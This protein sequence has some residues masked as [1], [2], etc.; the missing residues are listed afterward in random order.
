MRVVYALLL[1]ASAARTQI[2][3]GLDLRVDQ[4]LLLLG[5]LSDIHSFVWSSVEWAFHTFVCVTVDAAAYS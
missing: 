1:F 4:A 5:R 3:G 2:T